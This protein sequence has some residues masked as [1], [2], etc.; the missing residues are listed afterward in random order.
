MKVHLASVYEKILS[1]MKVNLSS[2]EVGSSSMK[3]TLSGV[4]VS[5]SGS[6]VTFSSGKVNLSKILILKS[7]VCGMCV[8]FS[9]DVS[10]GSMGENN[11]IN[12]KIP[13]YRV[14]LLGDSQVGKTQILNKKINNEF[15]GTYT[16]TIAA[17]YKSFGCKIKEE[18]VK[19]GVWDTAGEENFRGVAAV[20]LKDTNAVVFVYDITNKESFN[21]IPTWMN[22]AQTKDPKEAVY[23]LVGNKADMDNERAVQYNEAK[24]FAEGNKMQFFEVSAKD[25]KDINELFETIAKACA[26]NDIKSVMDSVNNIINHKNPTLKDS[27]EFKDN[28]DNIQIHTPSK[29]KRCNCCPCCNK[30]EDDYL[31]DFTLLK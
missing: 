1:S 25:G 27:Y 26:K 21:N 24:N 14:V 2:W 9:S 5:L 20:F 13:T 19:L 31:N 8:M 30:D 17:E 22:L 11:E 10:W 15:D 6:K 3:V 29:N 23:F 7:I 12:D 18:D 28:N 4:E 16:G